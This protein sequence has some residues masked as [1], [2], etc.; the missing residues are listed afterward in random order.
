MKILFATSHA[1]LPYRTG[2]ALISTHE[3]CRQLSK[4]G[5]TVAVQAAIERQ[6]VAWLANRFKA[7]LR[8][9]HCVA[10]FI[11]GYP[12]F[13]G[14]VT[15][16][17]CREVAE[18]FKPDVVIVV[19]AA[20]GPYPL[21]VAYARLGLPVIYQIRDC[22]FNRHGGDL[23]ALDAVFVSNSRFVAQRL[24][25]QFSVGSRIIYPPFRKEEFLVP[26]TGT[27]VLLI[28]PDPSKGGDI[29]IALAERRKDVQF[30]IQECW[31]NNREL[32][33]LKE[34]AKKSGNVTWHP[35]VR[36][37]REAYADA[38]LLLAPSKGEEAWGRVVTEAQFSGIP[39]LASDLGGLP[40]AV[41]E[42]GALVSA[43]ADIS[44]WLDAFSA[45]WDDPRRWSQLSQ[46]AIAHA[47]DPI[48]SID[49]AA[50]QLVSLCWEATRSQRSRMARS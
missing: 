2:G 27:K 31:P 30:R 16:E 9:T 13:R 7:K 22:M 36:D 6:G 47:N 32:L 18:R 11:N 19:G 39:V 45:I 48:F 21:A 34:R 41:G 12:T 20:P 15:D 50:D 3:F 42:G 25:Q 14:W 44:V 33:A 28:N 26:R 23:S 10:D 4:M 8:N 29:A 38:R 24:K 43:D 40:E 46:K 37:V 49:H 5:H 35:P 17:A 1:Y